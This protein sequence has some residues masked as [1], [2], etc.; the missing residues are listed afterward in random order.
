MI[1]YKFRAECLRDVVELLTNAKFYQIICSIEIT[2]DT[3]I[4][5][6]LPDVDVT[7]VTTDEYQLEDV[8]QVIIDT[9]ITDLHVVIESLNYSN[10]YTG[11]RY[12]NI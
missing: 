3:T 1:S 8:R 11:E 2:K 4:V 12:H 5:P 6:P 10:S 9:K 7:L